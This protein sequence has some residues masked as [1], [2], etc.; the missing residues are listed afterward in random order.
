[1]LAISIY[2]P[3]T[4]R[5]RSIQRKSYLDSSARNNRQKLHTF[6]SFLKEESSSDQLNFRKSIG[7]LIGRFNHTYTGLEVPP[8]NID[9]YQ[10]LDTIQRIPITNAA[11][12]LTVSRLFEHSRSSYYDAL[13]QAINNLILN[14]AKVEDKDYKLPK[15]L[16]E[17]YRD[18][19]TQHQI[20]RNNYTEFTKSINKNWQKK[21][22][23]IFDHYMSDIPITLPPHDI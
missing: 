12:F 11:S 16:L 8:L 4:S 3:L 10:V 6:I 9:T 7:V 1:M 22:D 19:R 20:M 17:E 13:T 15:D 14:K 2:S 18:N 23:T 21:P 5:V